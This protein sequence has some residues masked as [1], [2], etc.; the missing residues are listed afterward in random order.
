MTGSICLAVTSAGPP[1]GYGTIMLAIRE[2][3]VWAMAAA[4]PRIKPEYKPPISIC[5][6]TLRRCAHLSKLPKNNR[7]FTGVSI[8]DYQLMLDLPMTLIS[9]VK[10][11]DNLGIHDVAIR[12]IFVVTRRRVALETHTDPA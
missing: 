2:L 4:P 6:K 11:S 8:F 12:Q 9:Y 1:A 3:A 5:L 7:Y 10:F